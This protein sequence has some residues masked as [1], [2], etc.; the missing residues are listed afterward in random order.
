MYYIT[1]ETY[2]LC[3]DIAIQAIKDIPSKYNRKRIKKKN[4]VLKQEI[5]KHG[6]PL[7]SLNTDICKGF[8]YV[9]KINLGTSRYPDYF[10]SVNSWITKITKTTDKCVYITDTLKYKKTSI[11]A[12]IINEEVL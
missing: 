11:L 1:K 12:Y 4:E 3:K 6:Q 5:I 9:D 7:N 2:D 8:V 10:F